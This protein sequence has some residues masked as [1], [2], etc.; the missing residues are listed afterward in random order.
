MTPEECNQ[1][2]VDGSRVLLRYGNGDENTRGRV[3]AYSIVP[4]I[5]IVTD[6][7]VRMTWRRDMAELIDEDT[8]DA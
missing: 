7:G 4:V 5:H 1:A 3:F 8:R 2:V 6:D